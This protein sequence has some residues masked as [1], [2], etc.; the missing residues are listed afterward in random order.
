MTRT[1]RDETSGRQ[2]SRYGD[3]TTPVGLLSLVL[4]LVFQTGC[5]S[6]WEGVRER[7]RL[8]ALDTARN[9]TQR[10]QC[11]PGLSSLDRAEARLDIGLYALEA[12]TARVR[13]YDKLGLSEMASAHRRLLNDFYNEEPMALPE[14]DGSSIFRVKTISGGGYETPPG[15]LVVPQP[16]YSPYA[17]RSKIV[18]RVV[19]A[20]DLASNGTT[21]RIRV[22]E[23]PHPLLAT[24]AIEAISQ[25]KP[26]SSETPKLMPGGRYVATFIFEWRWATQQDTEFDS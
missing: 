22:L 26:K 7:E 20:F 12:T 1:K 15:W 11:G 24:W 9:Q 5:A 17:Q 6:M 23:M 4:L 16:R 10:G 8:F 14:A 2:G 18:G 21:K 19:I 13:C 3:A 25:A